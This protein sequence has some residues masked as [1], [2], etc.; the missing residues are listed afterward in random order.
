MSTPLIDYL[1][2]IM[3]PSGPPAAGDLP[4]RGPSGGWTTVA[5]GEGGTLLIIDSNTG[6]PVWSASTGP[7]PTGPRG[8]QGPPG[9][10]GVAATWKGIWSSTTTYQTGHGVVLGGIFYISNIDNNLNHNPSSDAVNWSSMAQWSLT[11]LLPEIHLKAYGA[12]GTVQEGVGTVH[13]TDSSKITVKSVSRPVG[14]ISADVGTKIVVCVGGSI[15]TGLNASGLTRTVTG[16]PLVTTISSVTTIGGIGYAVLASPCYATGLSTLRVV[17]GSDDST[18]I[19]QANNDSLATGKKLLIPSGGY[20]MHGIQAHALGAGEDC[21]VLYRL[22][23]RVIN[24]TSYALGNWYP[25]LANPEGIVPTSNPDPEWAASDLTV[26]GLADPTYTAN[27]SG[28]Q[29]NG[30]DLYGLQRGRLGNLRFQNWPYAGYEIGSNRSGA[31][32]ND[33]TGN[34]GTQAEVQVNGGAGARLKAP[35]ALHNLDFVGK[36]EAFNCGFQWGG[37]G[38]A[39]DSYLIDNTGLSGL[40]L[41][42]GSTSL[43]VCA[44]SSRSDPTAGIQYW[45]PGKRIGLGANAVQSPETPTNNAYEV[46]TVKSVDLNTRTVHLEGATRFDHA[47]LTSIGNVNYWGDPGFGAIFRVPAREISIGL[48]VS[49]YCAWGGLSIGQAQNYKYDPFS[50]ENLSIACVRIKRCGIVGAPLMK[51]GFF[52]NV[53]IS[54]GFIGDPGG[55]LFGNKAN[56]AH[57]ADAGDVA[58]RLHMS[59]AE[60]FLKNEPICIGKPG[61][62]GAFAMENNTV[63]MVIPYHNKGTARTTASSPLLTNLSAGQTWVV[64]EKIAGE[65]IPSNAYVVGDQTGTLAQG[66]VL[67]FGLSGVGATSGVD[68]TQLRISANALGTFSSQDQPMQGGD[69]LI[70]ATPLANPHLAN[71]DVFCNPGT[72]SGLGLQEVGFSNGNGAKITNLD[73]VHCY[74]GQAITNRDGVAT[75]GIFTAATAAFTGGLSVGVY[76]YVITFT[77][78]SLIETHPSAEVLVTIPDST[79]TQVNLSAIPTGPSGTTSRKIYRT[80]LNGQTGSE[81]LVGTIANNTTTTFTDTLPDASMVYP[82]GLPLPPGQLEVKRHSLTNVHVRNCIRNGFNTQDGENVVRSA[83]IASGNGGT[84]FLSNNSNGQLHDDTYMGCQSYGNRVADWNLAASTYVTRGCKGIADA[85]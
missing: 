63:A 3:S 54:S 46:I 27:Y 82:L 53:V 25:G 51:V 42:A 66:T 34:A 8:P 15:V 47:D 83:C 48:L 59:E 16:V 19:D 71:E 17:W 35:E 14:F 72:T 41:P 62:T 9:L 24:G 38:A 37:I 40:L 75:P 39:D 28:L 12:L 78:A 70:L 13:A 79:H 60:R 58:L 45:V 50:I 55:S 5:V 11:A 7:G 57:A 77:P 49:D 68:S 64:G 22:P 65:E 33:G 18:I 32:H 29:G 52:K 84:G 67:T 73:I 80:P 4:T 2:L 44:D 23:D 36:I 26:D 1:G 31:D 76:R 21:T 10:A 6:M 69:T 43:V 74:D 85:G 56:N 61:A 81:Q 20:F 30:M